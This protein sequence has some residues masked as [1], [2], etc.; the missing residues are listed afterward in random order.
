MR[1]LYN[2]PVKRNT[3][4]K[5]QNGKRKM[6]GGAGSAEWA[7]AVYG[8]PGQQ[9]AG[10]DGNIIKAT[11]PAS[12]QSGGG[13]ADAAAPVDAVTIKATPVTVMSA[14]NAVSDGTASP[15]MPK[16]IRGGRKGG[17][18]LTDIAVPAVLL[19][20]NQLYKRRSAKKSGKPNQKSRRAR[21]GGR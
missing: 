3:V 13:V 14:G 15:A 7:T 18:A 12:C 19:T 8:G 5:R 21:S 10:S 11:L 1:L 2:M 16:A 6:Q 4:N 17:S 20:V 9:T